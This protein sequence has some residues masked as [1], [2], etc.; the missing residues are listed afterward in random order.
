MR[1][2]EPLLRKDTGHAMATLLYRV[3]LL[4]GIATL[5]A[6]MEEKNLT[7]PATDSLTAISLQSMDFV[8][9]AMQ[10]QWQNSQSADMKCINSSVSLKT[11]TKDD[12]DMLL[13]FSA[14]E[15]HHSV[16]M[17]QLTCTVHVTSR[18]SFVISAV[19][20]E[21]SPCVGGIF[22]VLWDNTT[23]KHWD[24]CSIWHVPGPDFMTSS[25]VAHVRVELFDVTDP[26]DFAISIRSIAK[27]S[28]RELEIRYL[29]TTEG[30]LLLLL[31]CCCCY[32]ACLQ[33]DCQISRRGLHLWRFLCMC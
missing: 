22:L 11:L 2:E 1:N 3:S 18:P 29:S 23:R 21:H 30:L 10:K 26:F 32:L 25:H 28:N 14:P 4:T 15:T 19:L 13:T 20:L 5:M 7:T 31:L 12:G 9:A 16:Q 6:G 27:L 17:T 24:I 33:A 8:N